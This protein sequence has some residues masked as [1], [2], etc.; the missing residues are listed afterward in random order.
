[1]AFVVE[2]MCDG[3]GI[4]LEEKIFSIILGEQEAANKDLQAAL[5]FLHEAESAARSISSKD[6]TEL[7]TLKTPSD[8][9]RLVFDGLLILQ[10]KRVVDVRAEE[11]VGYIVSMTNHGDRHRRCRW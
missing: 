4:S 8:I 7:K 5:P 6:I 3:I 10:Q 11:K 2:Y 9:I 1:M